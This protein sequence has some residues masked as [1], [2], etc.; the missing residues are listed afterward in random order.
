MLFIQQ[1]ERIKITIHKITHYHDVGKPNTII[2]YKILHLFRMKNNYMKQHRNYSTNRIW[3]SSKLH[4]SKLKPSPIC[5]QLSRANKCNMDTQTSM[6]SRTVNTY[7]D[8]ICDTSPCRVL[9]I[10]I[11]AHL[12][13][14]CTNRTDINTHQW[15]DLATN[16]FVFSPDRV[17][18]YSI[19][20]CI[21]ASAHLCLSSSV[22]C[23]YTLREARTRNT[24]KTC[25]S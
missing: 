2:A 10:T 9:G 1:L 8:A 4:L 23:I 6:D 21:Y 15:S 18:G 16:Y 11:K 5:I 13:I 22:H 17:S 24:C 20:K 19:H 3:V 7:E 25:V 14:C 12:K